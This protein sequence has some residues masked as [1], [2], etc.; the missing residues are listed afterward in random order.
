MK[1]NHNL[2]LTATS[3]LISLSAFGWGQKGHDTTAYIAECHLTPT[4][5]DSISRILGGKSLVY[6]SNWPDN[7]CHTEKYAYT[8]TWHYKNID[9][10][11]EYS[12]VKDIK[13]GSIVSALNEQIAILNNPQ[14]SDEDKWLALVLTTHFLGDI[15]QPM[16]MGR[17]SD[18]G[19]NRHD[20]K[21]FNSGTNLHSAWDSR[22][23]ESA[24]KW[25]YSEWQYNIDRATPEE[26]VFIVEGGTPYSWGEET[27]EIAKKV[28]DATPIGTNVAYD[29][30]ADWTPVIEQQF[31]RGG[32]RLA[33]ILNEAF[34][35]EY[36]ARNGMKNKK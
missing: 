1:L 34:D 2:L 12:K 29:Y 24:H 21:F 17:L 4:A 13:E 23:P 20:I 11:Q 18:R 36:K 25:S 10:G 9:E 30:I 19:G 28:Y 27:Y 7:A 15:H 8:K 31:L 5:K 32:L 14:T 26:E 3:A 6:Y 16:H 33:D 22:L 35:P